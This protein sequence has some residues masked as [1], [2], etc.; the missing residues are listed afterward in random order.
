MDI[1]KIVSLLKN[2]GLQ[3]ITVG[4]GVI[5]FDDPACIYTIFDNILN[6]GWIV[7]LILTAMMLFGWG[8]LYIK[9]GVKIN[10]LFNNAKAILLIFCILSAVKPIVNVIYGDNLFARNC[11]RKS[12]S[13]SEVQK[14]ISMR[15]TTLDNENS[16]YEVFDM[17]DSGIEGHERLIIDKSTEENS[18][19][20]SS[21]RNSNDPND[22]DVYL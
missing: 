1:A 13:L 14:L 8:V 21:G 19:G 2:S 16:L 20:G 4:N 9:N 10:D 17:V 3:N 6:F 22:P 5:E 12:V 15:D 7:I 11:E 18:N